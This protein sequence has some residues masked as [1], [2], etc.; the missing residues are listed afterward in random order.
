MGILFYCGFLFGWL[1]WGLV[2]YFLKP[3]SE[4]KDFTSNV[5]MEVGE[6]RWKEVKPVS[7]EGRALP[8]SPR[9]SRS[10]PGRRAGV[11]NS[12]KATALRNVATVLWKP[13]K[14]S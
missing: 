4:T 14:K 12:A 11:L 6:G 9:R 7:T 5:V 2:V 13:L 1:V 8:A 3:A 10:E